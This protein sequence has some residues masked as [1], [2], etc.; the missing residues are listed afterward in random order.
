MS[1]LLLLVRQNRSNR[2]RML[3]K[4]FSQKQRRRASNKC[5]EWTSCSFHSIGF[6]SIFLCGPMSQSN[7]F[8][9]SSRLQVCWVRKLRQQSLLLSH[10]S[11]RAENLRSSWW[12]IYNNN[13]NNN[14]DHYLTSIR[15]K[16][17]FT[18]PTT[19]KLV[20]VIVVV[21]WNFIGAPESVLLLFSSN[22]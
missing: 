17:V 12:P 4:N 16:V 6:L 5:S 22:E 13:N 14:A 18:Q 21:V 3:L 10:K 11:L 7:R 9:W 15:S 8:T 2:R 19:V 20:L 1:L